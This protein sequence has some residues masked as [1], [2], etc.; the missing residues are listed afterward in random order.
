ME[1]GNRNYSF[2]A[3]LAHGLVSAGVEHVCISPGSRN[4]PLALTLGRHP[5][6][7][8][9][10]LHDE[11]SAGFFALGAAKATRSPTVLV[12]TSG[13]AAAEYFPAIVEAQ[14]AG[15]PLIV[16]TADRPPELRDVGAPQAIDQVKMF[17]D[18]VKW[19]HD[20]GV[21]GPISIAGAPAL[22]VRLVAE[23]TSMPAGPVHL[24]VPIRDPLAPTAEATGAPKLAVTS[25]P[26][27]MAGEL[28]AAAAD[29]QM[30][31]RLISG[32]RSLIVAG[33]DSDPGFASAVAD[34][35]AALDAPILADV[36]SGLR[37]GPHQ[38]RL[39]LAAPD[40]LAGAGMLDR[41]R[42]EVVIRFG[43][44]PTE[45]TV[46]RWLESNRDV[47]QIVIGSGGWRDPL[48]SASVIVMAD[49][50]AVAG[51]LVALV[52]NAPPNWAEGWLSADRR[53][54]AA[55]AAVPG[56]PGHFYEP[57]LASRLAETA[58]PHTVLYAAS[59]MPVRDL[60][61]LPMKSDRPLRFLANRG[62]NGVDG[63]ISSALG[64]AT[65]GPTTLLVGDVA[66]LHDVGALR[67]AAL[68]GLP[69][70]ILVVNNDGGGIFHLLPQADP[71]I[72][73]TEDFER[74]LATPHGTDFAAIAAAMGVKAVTLDRADA[75]ET[76]LAEPIGGPS[77]AQ[78]MTDRY[79]NHSFRRTI[80]DAVAGALASP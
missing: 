22:G 78:V 39:V 26:A 49:A 54:A 55:V 52:T 48:S 43:D 67:T 37:S 29:L 72:V 50:T 68:L 24:N 33:H 45:K 18:A 70:R 36:L 59:S 2:A 73:P 31:A 38:N 17:G 62:A 32:R 5:A 44:L 75:L 46:W 13:T 63:T 47:P 76:W 58:P 41:Y 25:P 23:A 80:R 35:A 19:F 4:T 12:C 7:R 30:V 14:L 65:L 11:R 53:T 34:L 42:P 71:R 57:I 66:G 10:V 56:Q 51:D 9:W 6:L 61:F 69:L 20:P 8:D 1:K 15:I 77:L 74:Y 64:A 28:R 21:P 79:V 16:V 60:G 27:A 3:G 40:L